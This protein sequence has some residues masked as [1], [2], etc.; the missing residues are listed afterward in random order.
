M[1]LDVRPITDPITASEYETL[2]AYVEGEVT[3]KALAAEA[4][5]AKIVRVKNEAAL[6]S[7]GFLQPF[8]PADRV[9]GQP[10]HFTTPEGLAC[11]LCDPGDDVT[12]LPM[13]I[14]G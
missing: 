10:T 6:V 11:I 1:K 8:R 13:A 14:G 4:M 5:E 3:A 9:K 7:R 12:G 2:R